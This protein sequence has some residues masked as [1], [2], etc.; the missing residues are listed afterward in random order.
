MFCNETI[1]LG[2]LL[3]SDFTPPNHC[4][5]SEEVKTVNGKPSLSRAGSERGS[6]VISLSAAR[7]ARRPRLRCRNGA[8]SVCGM[9]PP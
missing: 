4:A 5:V 2:L 7:P 3:A 6:G 9:S 1:V 8:R